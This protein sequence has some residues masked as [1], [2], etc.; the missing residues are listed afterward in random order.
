[1]NHAELASRQAEQ[2]YK[3]HVKLVNSHIDQIRNEYRERLNKVQENDDSQIN[4]MKYNIQKF[5]QIVG[6]VGV[7]LQD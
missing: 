1:M 3:S 6:K 2:E 7:D 5:A 4:F